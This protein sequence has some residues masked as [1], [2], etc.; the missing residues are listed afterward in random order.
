MRKVTGSLLAAVALVALPHMAVAQRRASAG[1]GGVAKNEIGVDLG[2]AYSHYGSGC[3]T[4]CG[5]FEAGT[6]VDIRW[7][8]MASGPLSFEPRFTLSYFTGLGGHNLSFTPDVNVLYRLGTASARR[9]AY[10]T[11]GL[12]LDWTNVGTSG[13]P[14]TSATQLSLNAGIGKRIPMESNAWRLEGFF[15]YN[16]ANTS[17]GVPS[18]FDIGARVGMSFWR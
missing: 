5:S 14:S 16:F 1:G 4:S 15:K 9:G 17:K 10:L 3:V 7:G 8:F 11:G 13:T 6:P 18:H 2:A 12:G